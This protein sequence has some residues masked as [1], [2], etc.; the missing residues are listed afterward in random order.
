MTMVEFGR[1]VTSRAAGYYARAAT[2]INTR[3]GPGRRG[4]RAQLA[5]SAGVQA[6]APAGPGPQGPAAGRPQLLSSRAP[7]SDSNQVTGIRVMM[8][9]P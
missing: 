4:A 3:R 9:A 1:H 5:A 8:V 2:V 6:P 7:A